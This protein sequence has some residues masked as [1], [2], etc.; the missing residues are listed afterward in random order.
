MPMSLRT[1]FRSTPRAVISVPSMRI[2][3]RVGSSSRLMHRRRVLLPEP[4]G[5]MRMITSRGRT[6]RLMPFRTSRSPNDLWTSSISRRKPSSVIA[7]DAGCSATLWLVRCRVVA[8]ESRRA[9]P[10]ED[11]REG[12]IVG[13][14]LLEPLLVVLHEPPVE[15]HTLDGLFHLIAECHTLQ[16]QGIAEVASGVFGEAYLDLGVLCRGK[17]RGRD[18]VESREGPP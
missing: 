4:D 10:R 14:G 13:R 8:L 7:S 9:V 12:R 1:R 15:L 18:L 5:P 17:V 2:R 11:G 3:P 16:A 6:R